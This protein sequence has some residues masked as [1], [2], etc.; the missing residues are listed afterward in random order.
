MNST[1]FLNAFR[2]CQQACIQVKELCLCICLP[3]SVLKVPMKMCYLMHGRTHF[4]VDATLYSFWL[5]TGKNWAVWL[6]TVKHPTKTQSYNNVEVGFVLSRVQASMLYRTAVLSGESKGVPASTT[7][8]FVPVVY[9]S[10]IDTPYSIA[11]Y[12]HRFSKLT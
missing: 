9:W 11:I 7:D 8:P 3:P 12:L 4:L 1:V 6:I 10:N 2:S 5:I